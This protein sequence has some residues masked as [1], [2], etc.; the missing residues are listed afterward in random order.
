MKIGS[1]RCKTIT[2]IYDTCSA[3]CCGY[4]PFHLEI[5]KRHPHCVE[6]IITDGFEPLKLGGVVYPGDTQHNKPTTNRN[7]SLN[8][9]CLLDTIIVYK[10]PYMFNN[11]PVTIAFALSDALSVNSII[12][13]SFIRAISLT[14]DP[15]N[16]ICNSATLAEAFEVQFLPPE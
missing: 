13:N 11:G 15:K 4:K 10:T 1:S 9:I 16:N 7:N 6:K 12:G 14:Y 2:P 5:A 8:K 3:L